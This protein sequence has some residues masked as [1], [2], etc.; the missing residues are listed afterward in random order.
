M[1]IQDIILNPDQVY[2]QAIIYNHSVIPSV[3]LP[4]AKCTLL[5]SY[6]NESKICNKEI[7]SSPVKA[8]DNYFA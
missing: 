8:L 6:Q 4:K 3:N 1:E 7:Q 5:T 2:I